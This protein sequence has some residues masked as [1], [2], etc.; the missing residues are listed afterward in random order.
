[1]DGVL[2]EATG[3]RRTWRSHSVARPFVLTR[4]KGRRQRRRRRHRPD[5]V[6][7]DNGSNVTSSGS[8][9]GGGGGEEREEGRSFNVIVVTNMCE[10]R[11]RVNRRMNSPARE[12]ESYRHR[13]V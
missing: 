4:S 9:I 13:V 3:L 8:R 6:D 11:A 10:R 7:D 5:L 12:V 1:M 2:R